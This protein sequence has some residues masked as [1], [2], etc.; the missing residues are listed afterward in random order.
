MRVW[1]RAPLFVQ[2]LLHWQDAGSEAWGGAGPD[3]LQDVPCQ[4]QES[5]SHPSPRVVGLGNLASMHVGGIDSIPHTTLAS[6]P[7]P[8]EGG[9]PSGRHPTPTKRLLWELEV[10]MHGRWDSWVWVPAHCQSPGRWANIS[11]IKKKCSLPSEA[12]WTGCCWALRLHCLHQGFG[13]P[14]RR[15]N[16]GTWDRRWLEH[17]V[18]GS[19]LCPSPT[20]QASPEVICIDPSLRFWNEV[21]GHYASG[22]CDQ[23][24]LTL[25]KIEIS[26]VS[27]FY[28]I[29][30]SESLKAGPGS[31]SLEITCL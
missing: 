29:Y 22:F 4:A 24:T 25:L 12:S 1:T 6:F 17:P 5:A 18:E 2:A 11:G 9:M 10:R 28:P 15:G 26:C 8:W 13:A 30:W 3:S 20:L 16:R 19:R 21:L 14:W 31:V 27:S 7:Q 23:R